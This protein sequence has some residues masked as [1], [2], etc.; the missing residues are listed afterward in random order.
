MSPPALP[1]RVEELLAQAGWVR[2]L[3]LRLARDPSRADDLAQQTL[4]TALQRRPD[5]ERPLRPWLAR[6]LAR[7]HKNQ[8]RGEARLRRRERAAARPEGSSPGANELL[9]QL[10]EQQRLARMVA[11]LPE[12][13]RAVVLRRYYSGQSPAEIAA[14][15]GCSPAT[16][17]SQLARG[18]ARLRAELD[19]RA[20]AERRGTL[21]ILA[22][23]IG[24]DGGRTPAWLAARTTETLA[25]KTS[26]LKIALASGV[27]LTALATLGGLRVLTSGG[28]STPPGVPPD[29]DLVS[30]SDG[31]DGA[32]ES[33]PT[34]PDPAVDRI[35]APEP[36]VGGDPASEDAP[37]AAT[38]V[39]LRAVD[40]ASL[41]LAEASLSVVR[42]DGAPTALAGS[43]PSGADGLVHIDLADEDVPVFFGTILRMRFALSAPW[44]AT[45][46]LEVAP[47]PQSTTDLGD[48]LLPPGGALTGLVVDETGRGVP[49]ARVVGCPAALAR[50]QREA[51][52]A[53]PDP[54]T[55]RPLALSGPGGA[56]RLA[57]LPAEET[58]LWAHA[59]GYAWTIGEPQWVEAGRELGGIRLI[60]REPEEGM[61]LSGRALDPAGL[62]V[63][64]AIV[65][66]EDQNARRE[67][68]L[69]ADGEG[70]FE[71][72]ASGR[73][74]Y[75][76]R[77]VDPTGGFGPSA[78]ASWRAG[79]GPL[80]LRLEPLRVLP[81]SVT[82]ED[83]V[84]LE[85]AWMIALVD[86][87]PTPG[88]AFEHTD[89]AGLA[90][91]VA[92]SAPFELSIGADG[93]V[94]A[95]R[96]PFD[97]LALPLELVVAL[98]REPLLRGI[99]RAAGQPVAGARIDLRRIPPP[100]YVL[101]TMGFPQRL[102]LG[103]LEMTTT[104]A[105]GRFTLG[106]ERRQGAIALLAQADGWALVEVQ[107]TLAEVASGEE[108][109][110]ELGPGGTLEGDVL[111]GASRAPQGVVVAASRGDGLA[112]SVRTDAEGHF[113][114]ERLT[115]GPWRVE[116]RDTEPSM[117]VLAVA[118]SEEERDFRWNCEIVEGR[119]TRLDLEL[120]TLSDV[121]LDGLFRVDGFPAS[122][123]SATLERRGH[124]RRAAP[125]PGRVIDE[126]GAFQ[127]EA[128]AG[129]YDLVLRS[130]EGGDVL[131]V[132]RRQ[133]ELEGELHTWSGEIATGTLAGR[134][135]EGGA[136]LRLVRGPY[137]EGDREIT[138]FSSSADGSF[139]AAGVPAGE[140]SFQLEGE[141]DYG[142][143]WQYLRS[144]T[145][146]AGGRT[147]LD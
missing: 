136:A 130:P 139:E 134:V 20:A 11:G 104:D 34:R 21:S 94:R 58:C 86:E 64:G 140:A 125:L 80:E 46:F 13:Y 1:A 10:E 121:L 85:G 103:N 97:P 115:P 28:G 105:E 91:V 98:E 18:L 49:D 40:E 126:S 70:R 143:G 3:A 2:A 76:L 131:I 141:G 146:A 51:R 129:S 110:I 72:V 59:R 63:P 67:G 45:R 88:R 29:A 32:A 79:G 26:T 119:A 83:G 138:T 68:R 144:V 42:R 30:P 93:F 113:R 65:H 77:A 117:E 6:V 107:L 62:P 74:P 25:M 81:V 57:G 127:L 36:E 101:L 60:L 95:P 47:E 44:R 41:P 23:A 69:E 5:G 16:V 118:N 8:A 111:V 145:I 33:E 106:I 124:D 84:P 90:R 75:A 122:G 9:E 133:L 12:P 35:A 17:R 147:E 132:A 37:A 24:A 116:T 56:F 39:A 142:L 108:V 38:R 137:R 53:G 73:A 96:G 82:D 109:E 99:V 31:P 114:F 135:E 4:L 52:Y 102:D 19:A 112:R 27:L 87:R 15:S 55:C 66:Y 7:L 22:L 14:I 92:P 48:V 50:T 43:N 71:L 123:W 61:K 78:A 89:A 54:E 128:P 100:G 120:S